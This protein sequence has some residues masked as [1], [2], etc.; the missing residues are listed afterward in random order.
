MVQTPVG[1]GMIATGTRS[2]EET[3]TWAEA[4]GYDS[5]WLP[6]SWG[7]DAFV[8]LTEVAHETDSITLG[9]GIANVFSR[10]PAVLAMASTTLLEAADG[11]FTLGLGVSHP[12]LVE[13]LHGTSYDRPLRRLHETVELLRAFTGDDHDIAFEG[14]VFEI[15][16]FPPIHDVEQV[17]FEKVDVEIYNAA[18]GPANRRL[19]GRLCDGWLPLTIPVCDLEPAFEDVA[20]GATEA[21]RDPE[22]VTVAPWIPVVA[23]DDADDATAVLRRHVIWYVGNL[24]A[25]RSAVSSRFPE[26]TTVG[27][28]WDEGDKDGAA[29]A[30]TDEMLDALGV[31]GTPETVRQQFR[32][33]CDHPLVDTPI[34]TVPRNADPAVVDRTLEAVAP[35]EL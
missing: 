18:L 10:S 30:V 27:E 23:A 9:T 11:R 33:V 7:Y 29:A 2:I 25:Y 6:E 24:D 31:A 35:S 1:V 5:V 28:R 20:E 22:D 26:A 17:A 8:K 15:E 21:D 13:G 14:E 3:A 16:W 12:E 34:V 19:T 32:E 4:A